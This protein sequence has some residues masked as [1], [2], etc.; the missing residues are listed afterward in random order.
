MKTEL[1]S[2]AATVE[3][4]TVTIDTCDACG[5]NT[6]QDKLRDI[7]NLCVEEIMQG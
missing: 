3:T 2:P 7:C 6:A 5:A 4:F 1:F